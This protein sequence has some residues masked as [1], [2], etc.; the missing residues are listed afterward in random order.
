MI[1]KRKV[2]VLFLFSVFFLGFSSLSGQVAGLR[3]ILSITGG[4]EIVVSIALAIWLIG[5]SFGNILGILLMKRLS[6]VK[7]Y[8]A[9]FVFT[10]ISIPLSIIL[11]FVLKHPIGL[12]TGEVAGISDTVILS[13]VVLLP[14]TV[15]FGISFTSS[16]SPVVRQDVRI[17][18]IYAFEAIG[19]I[20]GGLFAYMTLPVS[21]NT[22]S[23]GF[24]ASI[25]SLLAIIFLYGYMRGIVRISV[26]SISSVIIG[27]FLFS[28]ITGLV[29]VGYKNI[30]MNYTLPSY[31][32]VKIEA[33]P[34]GEVTCIERGGEKVLMV[35][36]SIV[37]SNAFT[38]EVEENAFI[39]LSVSD[40]RSNVLIVGDGLSG[41]MDILKNVTGITK[42]VVPIANN[43]LVSMTYDYLNIIPDDKRFEIVIDDPR[44]YI[45]KTD[46]SFNLI[47]QACGDPTT[48][49]ENRLFTKEF[50]SIAKNKLSENGVFVL[51]ATG[52]E[53]YIGEDLAVYLKSLL[54]TI[55]DVFKN[56]SVIPGSR[57]IF[58]A[59]DSDSVIGLNAEGMWEKIETLGVT[60]GYITIEGLGFRMID[61]QQRMLNNALDRVGGSINH[62]YHS[63]AY[64]YDLAYLM[65]KTDPK[66]S[67]I[68][69]KLRGY[70]PGAILATLLSIVLVLALIERKHT[71]SPV[72][73]IT[74]MGGLSIMLELLLLVVYQSIVGGL[75]RQLAIIFSVFMAGLAVGS[76]VSGLGPVK[77]W[78]LGVVSATFILTGLFLS[79]FS[80]LINIIGGKLI[81][82]SSV[83]LIVMTAICTGLLFGFASDCLSARGGWIGGLFRGGEMFGSTLASFMSGLIILPLIGLRDA[84]M[85]LGFAITVIGF[86]VIFVRWK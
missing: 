70:H 53:Q 10:V 2:G 35:N 71:T 46:L 11:L 49:E 73:L 84:I 30:R 37:G 21:L 15:P 20:A 56:V 1:E 69:R 39:P 41:E 9:S 40:G 59:S 16:A 18:S 44:R 86:L 65:A 66:V 45:S 42:V 22:L 34:Y 6:A 55:K 7:V 79:L 83:V 64:Y 75:Y 85:T 76:I 13:S 61:T 29:L 26:I 38:E 63:I 81:A 47:V 72:F 8:I 25:G 80:I 24:V 67:S 43:K 27:F 12:I 54:V 78:A 82:F 77:K 23:L 57:V 52:D 50:F 17:S 5:H 4:G 33:T 51:F 36:G 14:I 19:S 68:L 28:L 48:I 58:V 32:I 31:K 74:I 3:A 62:D 60:P